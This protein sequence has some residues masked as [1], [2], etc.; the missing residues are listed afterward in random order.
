[1]AV[2]TFVAVLL[3]GGALARGA[4]ASVE[5]VPAGEPVVLAKTAG[6]VDE[7]VVAPG[8][9]LLV[10]DADYT[11]PETQSLELYDS[12]G[13]LLRKLGGFGRSPGS[14]FRLKDVAA[15]SDGTIWAV[16]LVGRISFFGPR[17]KLRSTKLVQNP[18]YQVD[19]L[20]IDE[21]RGFFYL[22]GCLPTA[23]FLD[24][25]CQLVHQYRLAD[26]EYVRSFLPSD[27]EV[28]A[29]K[30]VALQDVSL[31]LDGRGRVFAADAPALKLHRVDPR[32]GATQVFPIRSRRMRP[33][34]AIDGTSE[35]ARRAYESSHLVERVLVAGDLAVVAVRRG[36]AG[37][38]LLAF[39]D[40]EGEPV[41]IDVA[42]PGQLVG[43]TPDGLLLF[44]ERVRG[45]FAVRRYSVRDARSR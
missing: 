8:G 19:G 6:Q 29:K 31:A 1:M 21:G 14:F 43:K 39:F 24:R 32:T 5:L 45:G 44:A 3:L 28:L 41:G 40:L 2:R 13:R 25:G 10:R 12:A 17:G 35:A 22:S 9:A 34:P 33:A 4:S 37:D 27:P 30:Q 26:K 23:E 38:S 20:A 18:G 36:R 7:V 16:D 11:R 42:P 15:T